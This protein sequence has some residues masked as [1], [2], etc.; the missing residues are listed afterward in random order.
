MSDRPKILLCH[1]NNGSATTESIT[2]GLMAQ[3]GV[4]SHDVLYFQWKTGLLCAGF[5]VGVAEA[6]KKGAEYFALLHSDI[7]PEPDDSWLGIM[8]DDLVAHDLD[9]IHAPACFKDF[10]GL[11]ST[12]VGYSEDISELKRRL[13]LYELSTLPQVFTI[14]DV[15]KRVDSDGLMLLPNTGCLLMRCDDWFRRWRGFTFIDEVRIGSDGTWHADYSPEDWNLGYE[16][17][18]SGRRVGATRRVS[19]G[20]WGYVKYK[21]NV[22]RGQKHDEKYLRLKETREA[23]A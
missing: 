19:V 2:A 7:E 17:H 16:C 15:R 20:H 4:K 10:S 1:P 5:N 6:K 22:V 13:T 18:A 23:V 11:S 14:D 9:V 12:A 3:R 21:T 8:L